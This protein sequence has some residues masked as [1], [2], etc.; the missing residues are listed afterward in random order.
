M[1]IPTLLVMLIVGIAGAII[2]ALL[3]V[4]IGVTLVTAD[5]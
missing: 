2:G 3:L 4:W 1:A 5:E